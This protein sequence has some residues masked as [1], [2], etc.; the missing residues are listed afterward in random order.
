ML[1]T[2]RWGTRLLPCSPSCSGT[3]GHEERRQDTHAW[4]CTM[5]KAEAERWCRRERARTAA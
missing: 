4:L 2:S 1:R 3:A 5:S